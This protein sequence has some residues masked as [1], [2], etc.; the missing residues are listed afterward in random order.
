M[1]LMYFQSRS[2]SP[3]PDVETTTAVWTTTT[4]R[5]RRRTTTKRKPPQPPAAPT[6]A[7]TT[8]DPVFTSESDDVVTQTTSSIKIQT[9]STNP[10]TT[11]STFQTTSSIQST[12]SSTETTAEYTTDTVTTS[13][14]STTTDSTSEFEHLLL[15]DSQIKLILAILS[16]IGVI[17]SVI[18]GCSYYGVK[19]GFC[20]RIFRCDC[21]KLICVCL[22]PH[23][24]PPHKSRTS[25]E[26]TRHV[27]SVTNRIYTGE[28][29][30][31]EDIRNRHSTS[32]VAGAEAA[33]IDPVL[34]ADRSC[35]QVMN[36]LAYSS[37]LMASY[38]EMKLS[39]PPTPPRRERNARYSADAES[40][41]LASLITQPPPGT[42]YMNTPGLGLPPS[43]CDTDEP[44]GG[45]RPKRSSH[46]RDCKK[47]KDFKYTA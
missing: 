21:K 6:D 35:E 7:F 2:T 11:S 39:T 15:R 14:T 36:S 20:V 30:S 38:G 17:I 27:H 31:L 26:T 19:L 28:Y 33:G 43:D 22:N 5:Q 1:S 32:E 9:T 34:L 41:E 24:G 46:H 25:P 23:Q 4:I 13:S 10:Q 42:A 12:T 29:A 3:A 16:T 45:A 40:H 44:T 18:I 47:S 37:A 8:P